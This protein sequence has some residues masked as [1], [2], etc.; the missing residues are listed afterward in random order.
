MIEEQVKGAPLVKKYN[1]EAIP[2]GYMLIE[3][4]PLTSVQYISGSMPIPRGKSDIACAHAMAAQCLGM[5]LV[6]LEAG[7]GASQPV[8]LEMVRSVSSYI[9]IPVVVGGGLHTPQDCADQVAAGASFVVVGNHLEDDRDFSLLRELAA[10]TH[11]K[12]MVKT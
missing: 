9:N 11:S 10:A 2:T 1:L 8:P 4:G 5:K 6:Y 3:S 12:D 7:S